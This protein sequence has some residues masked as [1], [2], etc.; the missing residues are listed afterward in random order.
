MKRL[1]EEAFAAALAALPGM[2]PVRLAAALSQGLS[3]SVP[4][5]AEREEDEDLPEGTPVPDRILEK[6]LEVLKAEA[7]AEKAAA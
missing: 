6:G 5:A 7:P 4:V 2:G 1:P 3:P